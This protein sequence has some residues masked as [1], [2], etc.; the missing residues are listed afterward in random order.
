MR[1]PDV[2]KSESDLKVTAK[3]VSFD[4]DTKKGIK[5]H[6]SLDLYGEIDPDHT[7]VNHNDREV[8][9]VLRKKELKEEF[10][11]RLLSTTKKAHF[12]KTNFDKVRAQTRV[13]H[14]C[15]ANWA[16]WVDEDEQDEAADDDYANNFGG[17]GEMG[18]EGLGNIDFSKLGGLDAAAAAAGAGGAGGAEGAEAGE[19]QEEVGLI[20]TCVSRYNTDITRRTRCLSLSPLTTR[21]PARLRFRR[22]LKF[23]LLFRSAYQKTFA[24]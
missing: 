22:F 13:D 4:G 8:E 6:V 18:N 5:Y 24:L 11:P 23:V 16:Q 19:G 2:P 3:N 20:S 14:A 1:T 10:W 17:L 12:L 21:A 15:G 7:K 9:L